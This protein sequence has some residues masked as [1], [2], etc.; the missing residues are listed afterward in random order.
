MRHSFVAALCVLFAGCSYLVSFDR[1]R[2]DGGGQSHVDGGPMDASRPDAGPCDEATHAG[3]DTDE[4]CCAGACVTVGAAQCTGC[5]MACDADSSS[6]C[7]ERACRCGEGD[8]CSGATPFCDDAAGQCVEC[9]DDADC[10]GQQ[11]VS[12][13]CVACDPADNSGCNTPAAPICEAATNTCRACSTSPDDCPDPLTCTA[14]GACG[15]CNPTTNAG[16][17]SATTPICDADTTICR[18]CGSPTECVDA[19]GLALCLADGRCAACDPADN[20]GC[21]GTTPICRA[22]TGGVLACAVCA[23]GDCSGTTPVCA[24][25]GDL[26]GACVEC[27]ASDDSACGSGEVCDVATNACVQCTTNGDCTG[28]TPICGTDH[29]CRACGAGECA[30]GVCVTSG[31]RAGACSEC[32][33]GGTVVCGASAPV[34]DPATAMCSACTSD[35]DCDAFPSARQCITAGGSSGQCKACDPT[36]NAGCSGTTPICNASFTCEGCTDSTQCA[37]G[38]CNTSTGACGCT[39]DT[40]CSGATPICGAGGTCRACTGD[41]ECPGAVCVDSGPHDGEC[42]AC[43][44]SDDGGCTSTAPQCEPTSLTCV[45]CLSDGDCTGIAPGLFCN[46]SNHCE[47]K[48]GSTGTDCKCSNGNN[49]AVGQVCVLGTLTCAAGP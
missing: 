18:A 20:T 26:A 2:I 17:T 41:V 3:C 14:S 35:T 47:C 36:G 8:A 49:C 31:A 40:E 29:T 9:R 39:D 34:C 11:C 27:D 22:G 10:G 16:C 13:Q 25:S 45:A 15:G 21:S 23:A 1:S 6:T 5:G 43:D 24:T 37:T 30:T 32:N 44:P 28:T 46:A 42:G 12:G 19:A 48:A 7:V 38:T 4:L 33:P